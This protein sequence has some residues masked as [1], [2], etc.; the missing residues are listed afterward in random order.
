MPEYADVSPQILERLRALCLAL[1]ESHEQQAWAG[2]R[3]RIRQ[4]TFAHVLALDSEWPPSY[5]RAFRPAGPATLL[6]IRAPIPELEALTGA[7]HPFY[8]PQWGENV[9]GMVI[10][11]DTDWDEVG[12]LLAESYRIQAP[13]KLAALVE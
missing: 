2:I 12:E 13:R 1:P 11:D 6:T 8:R 4:K 5:V 3:W 9:L 10:D 7:G